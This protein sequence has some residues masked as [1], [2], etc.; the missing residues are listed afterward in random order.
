M[1]GTD[2]EK[3]LIDAF[4]YKFRPAVHVTC[5]IHVRKNIKEKLS[6]CSIFEEV[7]SEIIGDIFGKR[8]GSTLLEGLVDPEYNSLESNVTSLLDKWKKHESELTGIQ[9]FCEWFIKNKTDVIS[10]LQ[11]MRRLITT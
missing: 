9:E 11:Y 10:L 3:A 4:A 8:V 7:Q 2:G 6:K 1:F 5:F